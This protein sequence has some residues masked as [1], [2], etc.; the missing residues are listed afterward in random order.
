M[1][2]HPKFNALNRRSAEA[3]PGAGTWA[4]SLPRLPHFN[5]LNLPDD[6]VPLERPRRERLHPEGPVSP[7]LRRYRAL[8]KIPEATMP[9]PK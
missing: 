9:P 3:C 7:A 1:N 8:T 6:W 4:C 5:A 2:R